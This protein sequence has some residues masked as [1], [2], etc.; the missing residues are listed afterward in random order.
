MLGMK[1]DKKNIKTG[2][3]TVLLPTAAT[4]FLANKSKV[5]FCEAIP[6]KNVTPTKV[7]KSETLKLAVIALAFIPPQVPK[8]KAAPKDKKPKLTF[9]IKPRATTPIKT[10][11]ENTAIFFF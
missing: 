8:I 5:P 4:H 9:L 10:N 7:T 2:I 1:A 6:N 11:K 3:K